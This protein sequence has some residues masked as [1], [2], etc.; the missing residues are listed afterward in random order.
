MG[1]RF[2][3][4]GIYQAEIQVAFSCHGR[5]FHGQAERRGQV[6]EIITRLNYLINPDDYGNSDVSVFYPTARQQTHSAESRH[7]GPHLRDCHVIRTRNEGENSP[8]NYPALY[9]QRRNNAII[10]IIIIAIIISCSASLPLAYTNVNIKYRLS[11]V[12]LKFRDAF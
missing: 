1:L 2:V 5:M 7:H 6:V 11:F 8:C 4:C 9:Y 12:T 10:L 3:C